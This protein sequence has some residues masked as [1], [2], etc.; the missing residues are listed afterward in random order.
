MENVGYC[1]DGAEGYYNVYIMDETH[2]IIA[3]GAGGVSKLRQPGGTLLHR[4]FNYKYPYEYSERFDTV[5]RRKDEI[6]TF[7]EQSDPGVVSLAR[8][9]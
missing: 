8:E 7:Y 9:K 3:L 4:I 1:K 5:L 6:V 2:S